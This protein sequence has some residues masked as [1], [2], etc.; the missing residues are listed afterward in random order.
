MKVT[1][2]FEESTS[3]DVSIMVDALRASTTITLALNN[4]KRV[5][6]CFTPEE[7]F[8]LKNSIG[9]ILA[10]ERGGKM[11]EGFD[12][13]NTPSGI[14]ELKTSKDTLILTTSNGTRILK[15]MNSKVLIGSMVN[16]KAVAQKCIQLADEHVD[17]VMAGVKGE[18]AI[19]DF[20]ASGEILYWINENLNECELSEYAKSAILASRDY[21][22]LK[23]AFINSRSAK[24]LIG[25]GYED[26][27]NQCCLKNI[28]DNVAIYN[29]NEL[30]LYI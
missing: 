5:I 24:R 2:S 1:L 21:K 30:T 11:I 23:D 25:L 8:D 4:F 13:G 3:N 26:D 7:G 15:N 14:K 19:E 22:S 29:N 20:L 10:G 12:I 9:G 27:V 17:V 6:P 16:A 28:S 18:F